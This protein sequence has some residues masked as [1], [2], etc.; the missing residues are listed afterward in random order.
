[1][2]IVNL[3]EVDKSKRF[4]SSLSSG[5]VFRLLTYRDTYMKVSEGA[6]VNLFDGNIYYPTDDA[7]VHE[8]DAELIVKGVKQ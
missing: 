2:K 4:F 1:M 6:Y 5:A 7:L 3:E 8:L